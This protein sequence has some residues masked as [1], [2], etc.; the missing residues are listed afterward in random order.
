MGALFLRFDRL[1]KWGNIENQ[2]LSQDENKQPVSV[3]Q[4]NK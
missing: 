4:I 2:Y 1:R 3:I